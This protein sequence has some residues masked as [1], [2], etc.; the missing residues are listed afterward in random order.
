MLNPQQ[1]T[2]DILQK[3]FRDF[4][5]EYGL[6]EFEGIQPGKVLNI[7]EKEKWKF[8]IKCFKRDKDILVFNEEKNLRK[9]EEIVR[10]LWI[11]KLTKYYGYPLERI[12]LEKDIKF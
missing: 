7:F 2:S 10:Q 3:I 9:P 12:D 1:L 11:Y 5:T 4:S 6:R 8:Y